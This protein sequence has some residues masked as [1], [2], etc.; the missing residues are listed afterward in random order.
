MKNKIDILNYIESQLLSIP[1]KDVA[2]SVSYKRVQD[3]VIGLEVIMNDEDSEGTVIGVMIN[4]LYQYRLINELPQAMYS[5]LVSRV[6]DCIIITLML[7]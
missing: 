5:L 7:T 2:L 1:S 4:Y 3:E 6:D